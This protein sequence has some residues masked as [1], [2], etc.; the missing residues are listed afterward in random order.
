MIIVGTFGIFCI[1]FE[2]DE[3]EVHHYAYMVLRILP[4]FPIGIALFGILNE[5][6]RI[7]AAISFTNILI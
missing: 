5:P 2:T 4:P 7:E 3:G 1:F 6:F